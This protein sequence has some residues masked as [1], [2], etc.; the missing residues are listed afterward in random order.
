MSM[1]L[2]IIWLLILTLCTSLISDVLVDTIDGF[3]QK[4][5]LSEVF[6]SVIIIPYFSN[7]TEQ[8]SAV[9]F[10]YKNEMD[11]CVGIT[12]GSALQVSSFVLP[13][14]VL[15]GWVVGEPISLYFRSYESICFV[16]GV[17]CIGAVIQGGTTNWLVGLSFIGIYVMI[18]AGF[19]FHEVEELSNVSN[20][21]N[22]T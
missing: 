6:T 16:F 8:I 19:W 21:V 22:N 12:V 7:I 9:I 17:L 2:G 20:D 13:A 4:S 5:H 18:A 10:A 15:V 3:A 11:L 14:C 1:R